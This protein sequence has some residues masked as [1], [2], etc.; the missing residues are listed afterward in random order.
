MSSNQSLGIGSQNRNSWFRQ[1]WVRSWGRLPVVLRAVLLGCLV[2]FVGGLATGPLIFA[3]TK[4]RPT[5]PW[6]VPFLAV[7]M[8]LF[9]Q[10]LRGR[11]WPRSTAGVRREGLRANA[12]SS[13]VW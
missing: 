3:N 4:W 12:L 5:F 9:W 7:Y 1:F 6:S 8:W 11:W 2:L 13:R 10:Y